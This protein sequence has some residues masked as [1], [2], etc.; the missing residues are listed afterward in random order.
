[1]VGGDRYRCPTVRRTWLLLLDFPGS[2]KTKED[3]DRKA[4]NCSRKLLLS[5]DS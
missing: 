5:L 2:R 4:F 3:A 1:M